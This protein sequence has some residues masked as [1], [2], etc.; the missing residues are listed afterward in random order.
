MNLLKI[1]RLNRSGVVVHRFRI[2]LEPS[3]VVES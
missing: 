1:T 2:L 3:L